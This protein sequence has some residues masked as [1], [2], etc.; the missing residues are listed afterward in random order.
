MSIFFDILESVPKPAGRSIV[1]GH[2]SGSSYPGIRALVSYPG[3]L[4][5][6]CIRAS[7]HNG[8]K[9]AWRR[10]RADEAHRNAPLSIRALQEHPGESTRL[11]AKATGQWPWPW[12]LASGLGHK[13]SG[14]PRVL[15][16]CPDGKG[17]VAMGFVCPDTTPGRLP[18][19]MPGCPD[20]CKCESSRIGNQCPD[21]RIRAPG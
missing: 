21:A 6:A 14:F 12:P 8:G 9:P 11:M 15:L 17:S 19:I 16:Q 20:T 7:G 3:T 5:F 13:P 4:A 2:S 1:S 18:A 10:I